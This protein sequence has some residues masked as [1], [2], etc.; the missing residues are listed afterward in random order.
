MLITKENL[1]KVGVKQQNINLYYPYIEKYSRLYSINTKHRIISFLTNVLLESSYLN[2]V[3]ENLNYT[4]KRLL[5]IFPKY[6]NKITAKEYAMQPK[7]IAS[8]VYANR[9]GNG[10]EVTEEGWIHRGMGAKQLTG[11]M[12]QTKFLSE[13]GESLKDFDKIY[14]N[15]DLAIRSA[16]WFWDKN[17]INK[18]ADKLDLETNESKR[19][20]IYKSVASV[21]NTGNPWNTPIGWKERELIRKKLEKIII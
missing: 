15:P 7:K 11:K 20:D 5:E 21:I 8:K 3:V 9:M 10:S 12:N 1:L 6:F 4:E 2:V 14:K 17:K 18:Y 16:F 13:I 19:T